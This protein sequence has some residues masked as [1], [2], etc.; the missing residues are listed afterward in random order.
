MREGS[1]E[2]R[3]VELMLKSLEGWNVACAMKTL[4]APVLII[5][6]DDDPV[7]TFQLLRE[8]FPAPRAAMIAA[9]GHIPWMEEPG[10]FWAAVDPFL[11]RHAT[12]ARP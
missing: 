12:P 1:F 6:G 5:E 8:T 3:V 2:V 4:A 11:A 10:Q 7:G 9:A